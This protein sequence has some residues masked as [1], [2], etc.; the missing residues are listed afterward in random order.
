M[1]LNLYD[2][3]NVGFKP[4]VTVVLLNI[5]KS[6][7]GMFF[8]NLLIGKVVYRGSPFHGID[9][10]S[11]DIF[12]THRRPPSNQA[13]VKRRSGICLKWVSPG[14]DGVPD[15]IVFLPGRHIGFV[16][17]K[18]PGEVPRPLQYCGNRIL[19]YELDRIFLIFMWIVFHPESLQSV[20]PHQ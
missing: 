20:P 12:F 5:H 9:Q 16:E 1:F 4:K 7:K 19:L 2:F 15:R 8:E 3:K 18:A 6:F 13:A 14:F 10:F 11:F 17:V